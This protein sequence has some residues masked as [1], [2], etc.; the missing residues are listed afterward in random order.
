MKNQY[1]IE[2]RRYI[3]E[4]S[5]ID[6]IVDFSGTKVFKDAAV[7]SIIVI[8]KS[9]E[10]C[11]NQ[12]QITYLNEIKDFENRDYSINFFYQSDISKNDDLSLVHIK[13][14]SLMDK[15]FINCKYLEEVVNFDQ[16]I[17][18][19]DNKR[20]VTTEFINNYKKLVTGADFD[21]YSLHY[22]GLYIN[23]D[24]NALHRSR[25]PE[26]F[27]NPV[28]ILLRQTGSY[29]ICTIDDE[30][31]YTLDTVH[32]GRLIDES[33]DILYLLSILNSKLHRYIYQSR[34]NEQGK[35]FAQV[36][37][38]YINSLPIKITDKESQKKHILLV[39]EIL[40]VN[41]SLQKTFSTF[42]SRIQSN[43]TI[44]K[45]SNKLKEFYNYDF[46]NFLSELKKK[47]ITIALK[48]QDE[49]ERYFNEY[50]TEINKLQQQINQTDKEIDQLV[51][52]LYGLTAE[53]IKIVEESTKS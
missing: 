49:W 18:T 24:I 10:T 22:N 8:L 13:N 29:P 15:V 31:Y 48:Q 34:I 27:E 5:N 30:K 12:N 11:S 14:S 44:D 42:L 35:V 51:Y 20:F 2:S 50:K 19:G 23:Y 7:D 33:Y 45:P 53:E 3:L 6:T 9:C 36:K 43:F 25:K 21:R 28:K 4:N 47:K 1:Y 16:G 41:K 40:N 52:Q 17:I 37:I 32:N 38:I 46:K 26:V 39:Q